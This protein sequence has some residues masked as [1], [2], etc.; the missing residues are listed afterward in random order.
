[1][2]NANDFIET[3]TTRVDTIFGVTAV[4]LAPEHP[5]VTELTTD[6]HKGRVIQYIEESRKKSELERT[7]LNKHKT[8]VFIGS[9]V[10]H[11]LTGEKVPVWI[12]DYVLP[13]YGT[14]SVMMVPSHDER[15]FEF[16]QKY[17]LE[18]KSVVEPVDS[19]EVVLNKAFTDDGKLV[20]S[21]EFNGLSS[22]EARSAI[23]IRLENEN[24][25]N[26]KE[27]FKLRDWLVSR[28][29]Y[30]GSPI[31][32][33]YTPAQGLH[34][35]NFDRKISQNIGLD[36]SQSFP[37][38]LNP[39]TQF[40][41]N[42]LN[43]ARENNQSVINDCLV[44]N[45][46]NQI[47][48][49]KRSSDRRLYPNRWDFPGGHLDEGE[50][51]YSSFV[52]EVKE[53]TNWDVSEVMAF[54]GSQEWQVPLESRKEGDNP[55]KIIYQFLIKV[56]NAPEL[57]LENGKAVEGRW[58]GSDDLSSL[59]DDENFTSYIYDSLVLAFKILN[60]KPQS[61]DFEQIKKP[62]LVIVHGGNSYTNDELKDLISERPEEIQ[63]INQHSAK[64][65]REE[66]GWYKNV[67][68]E[69][70]NRGFETFYPKMPN[71]QNAK[72]SEWKKAFESDIV[73]QLTTETH[74]VGHSLGGLFL[75]KFLAETKIKIKALHLVSPSFDE[76][77]F[78]PTE[79]WDQINQNCESIFIWHSRDDKVVPFN[80]ALKYHN[81][82]TNS[83]LFKFEDRGH[84]PD[85]DFPELVD[86]ID[87]YEKNSWTV[88]NGVDFRLVIDKE[89]P[90][91][92]PDDVD[93]R[94]DG[95]S[96]L[97]YSEIFRQV[98]CPITN[99]TESEGVFREKDTMDTF[100]CSSWYYLRYLDH[101]N[102]NEFAN[103]GRIQTWMPVDIYVGGAEHAVLHLLY[104]RFFY[105]ALKDGHLL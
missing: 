9:Y 64:L 83:I 11:P 42:L 6:E 61:F 57:I 40:L 101:E 99:L 74:L 44:V 100:V 87:N 39:D 49:Q 2:T 1:M 79:N 50:S 37:M 77:D 102:S 32:I 94:P 68:S 36:L 60:Q 22:E 67:E 7:D 75:I 13:N 98:K 104:A 27:Q 56:S 55:H 35:C 12:A 54:I 31:P 24:S 5:A 71:S 72:Y 103:K 85:Q 73:P 48:I 62:R 93:F 33:I 90:V 66:W 65:E 43:W 38:R 84:F 95:Q 52:R 82:L 78:T 10:E 47:F 70:Q 76:G 25:G 30:W 3:Y 89:L 28:Q 88:F 80:E 92:L 29:R 59:K 18:S 8:G 23:T 17:N 26:F 34:Q 51:I 53:E 69:L 41:E 4:V 16:A 81:F 86:F 19:T 45:E 91:V 58:V 63:V 21:Q 15:D 105:K 46:S 20:N 96:P 14:G 97:R